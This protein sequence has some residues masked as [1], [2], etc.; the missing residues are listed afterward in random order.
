MVSES[1]N[2]IKT[3]V[4]RSSEK[5]WAEMK[6]HTKLLIYLD[7]WNYRY[8]KNSKSSAN[9]MIGCFIIDWNIWIIV[10]FEGC[11]SVLS[12]WEAVLRMEFYL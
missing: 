8:D 12:V 3:E 9:L 5:Y 10:Y 7:F 1:N 2:P 11:K 6:R 4:L